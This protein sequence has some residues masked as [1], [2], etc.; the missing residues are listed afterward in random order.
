[1]GVTKGD[2]TVGVSTTAP[3]SYGPELGWDGP[4]GG[5]M[6]G[7]GRAIQ[8]YTRTSVPGSYIVCALRALYS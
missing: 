7:I 6:R 8:E 1:M 5:S 4:A 3:M 2:T